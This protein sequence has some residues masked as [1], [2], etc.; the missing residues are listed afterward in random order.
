[1]GT[2]EDLQRDLED[3]R[4]EIA[5]ITAYITTAETVVYDELGIIEESII[6]KLLSPL[7]NALNDLYTLRVPELGD[8]DIWA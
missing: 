1:M 3:L 8:Y 2:Q 4:S 7:R 6:L 5:D